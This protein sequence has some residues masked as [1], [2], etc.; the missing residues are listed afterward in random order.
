[1]EGQ[2]IVVR[3]LG[4]LPS[5]TMRDVVAI[6]FRHRRPLLSCFFGVLVG[7]LTFAL[8][9]TKYRSETEILVRRERVDPVVSPQQ[10][11]PIVVSNQITEEEMN[12]EVELIKS[13]DVMRKIALTCGLD[14]AVGRGWFHSRTPDDRLAIAVQNLR[15]E[16]IVEALPKTNIIRV[17]YAARDA[18]LAA[19]VLDALDAVYL[20]TH[21]EMHH[22]AGEL[23]FFDQQTKKASEHLAAAEAQLKAFPQQSGM[24]NPT[25]ARDYTLQKLNEFNFNLGQTRASIA[26][27]QKRITSLEQLANTTPQ[28]LTT[29]MRQADDG[30]VLQQMKSALLT[31]QLKRSDTASKYQ[32]DYPPL[33][34]L[35]KEIADTQA[36]I[37]A[38]KPLGD[39]TTDENPA[40]LWIKGELAKAQA[41][42]RGYEAKA[43]ETEAIIRQTLDRARQLE[44][45]GIEQQDLIRAAKAAEENYLLYLRKREEARISEALDQT[46][47]LNV[48]VA[49][50]PAVPRFP[51]ESPFMVG[52]FGAVLALVATAGMGFTLEYRDQSFRTPAEVEAV[53]EVPLLASVSAESK[54]A[55]YLNNRNGN[56]SESSSMASATMEGQS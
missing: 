28:R 16:L 43:S 48:S 21:R 5:W 27:T 29:Q 44:V 2:E 4:A 6:G 38:E 51:A 20:Q 56:G 45:S 40:Y 26:E 53:L 39:V 11:V 15:G 37:A 54:P 30:A 12:S 7:T 49:E 22:P 55:A 31:L 1:M 50:T 18:K 36:A 32:P 23:A 3:N 46:R 33:K 14:T 52:L 13:Q 34:E 25:L 9:T 41:D 42:V 47:I 35:D 10:N 8:L 24:A 19:R 17:S